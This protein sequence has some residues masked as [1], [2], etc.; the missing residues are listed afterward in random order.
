M[1]AGLYCLSRS[2]GVGFG[3]HGSMHF[4]GVHEAH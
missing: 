1:V 3:V 4:A 2:L